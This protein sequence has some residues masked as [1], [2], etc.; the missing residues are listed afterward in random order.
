[1]QRDNPVRKPR[2]VTRQLLSGKWRKSD[3]FQQFATN[4]AGL[5]IHQ[6]R[7]TDVKRKPPAPKKTRTAS[8]LSVGLD[9]RGREPPTLQPQR[10]RHA[11][12][13][14]AN[15]RNV[16]NQSHLEANAELDVSA[17]DG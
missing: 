7:G 17:A 13:P 3:A 9:D 5:K 14:A 8:R 11:R 1:V 12:D 4:T 10:R 6:S 16:V 15:D 2:D